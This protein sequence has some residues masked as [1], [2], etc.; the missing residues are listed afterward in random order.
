MQTT[1]GTPN[2]AQARSGPTGQPTN[3]NHSAAMR[4]AN[5]NAYAHQTPRFQP[6]FPGQHQLANYD[7]N[8]YEMTV[9]GGPGAPMPI[10]QVHVQSPQQPPQGQQNIPGP[11]PVNNNFNP[12]LPIFNN[13][14]A[15]N[16]LYQLASTIASQPSQSQYPQQYQTPQQHG[17]PQQYG[18]PQQYGTP[19]QHQSLRQQQQSPQQHQIPQF[20]PPQ[21]YQNPTANSASFANPSG[22]NTASVDSA[23]FS[24]TQASRSVDYS[25]PSTPQSSVFG[26]EN[27]T[28]SS[29]ASDSSPNAGN[30]PSLGVAQSSQSSTNTETPEQ[31]QKRVNDLVE[32]KG[33]AFLGLIGNDAEYRRYKHAVWKAMRSGGSYE[34]KAHDFPEDRDGQIQIKKR[35]VDAFFNLDGEQD[36]ATETGEFA[37]CL[38]VKIVRGLSPIQAELLAHELMVSLPATIHVQNYG[39]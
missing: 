4:V 32:K 10:A 21:Q 12:A 1:N 29:S 33:D 26:A 19:Q 9:R 6:R 25:T 36:P 8:T 39:C 37:N 38:A 27:R 15:M 23:R 7:G 5:N 20:G 16:A 35:I 34:N 28:G 30:S 2:G 17:T 13:P 11:Q 3:N 18:N 14:A 31:F 24:N 22:D